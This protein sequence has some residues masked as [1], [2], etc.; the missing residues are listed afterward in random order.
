[1]LFTIK[2]HQCNDSLII[3]SQVLTI[4][5]FKRSIFINLY[6]GAL[7]L[8]LKVNRVPSLVIYFKTQRKQIQEH[9][10]AKMNSIKLIHK[11]RIMT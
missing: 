8:V 9:K 4:P 5:G 3:I 7:R 10:L 1:M 6:N 11:S 2:N